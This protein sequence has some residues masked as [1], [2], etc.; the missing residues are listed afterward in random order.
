M[1]RSDVEAMLRKENEKTSVLD[2]YA[3][4]VA[5]KPYH[6]G[7]AMPQFQKFDGR[8]GN[9]KEHVFASLTLWNLTKMMRIY[10]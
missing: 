3:A 8:Q 1:I 5:S 4:E 10:A 6:T 9:T 7:Y 2:L